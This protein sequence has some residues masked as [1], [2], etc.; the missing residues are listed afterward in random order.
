MKKID[1]LIV[2]LCVI[3]GLL[4]G[5]NLHNKNERYQIVKT[6]D[7]IILLDKQTGLTWRN[8]WIDE[9]NKILAY[10][11]EMLITGNENTLVPIG[12]KKKKNE[13]LKRNIYNILKRVKNDKELLKEVR[14]YYP[15]CNDIKDE[16]LIKIIKDKY[17]V[18]DSEL[19]NY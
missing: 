14:K 7:N 18:K 1:F 6:D 9:K 11:D 3:I 4:I 8:V 13:E 16:K 10:W 2:L 5:F 19:L 12:K 17:S 15:E